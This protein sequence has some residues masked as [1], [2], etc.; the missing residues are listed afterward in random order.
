MFDDA[1]ELVARE[2]NEYCE[3]KWIQINSS[4]P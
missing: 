4:V 3:H 1:K 2:M